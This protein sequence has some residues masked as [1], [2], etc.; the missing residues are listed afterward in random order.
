[1]GEF[2]EACLLA[3]TD[4]W[5]HHRVDRTRNR[6]SVDLDRLVVLTEGKQRQGKSGFFF[7]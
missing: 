3:F 4:T 5:L 1:M 7:F 2:R 6:L